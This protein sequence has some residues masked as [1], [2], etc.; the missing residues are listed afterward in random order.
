MYSPLKPEAFGIPTHP[1]HI[2]PSPTNLRDA[3]ERALVE[4]EHNRRRQLRVDSYAQ[5]ARLSFYSAFVRALSNSCSAIVANAHPHGW[6][7]D[8]PPQEIPEVQV[9]AAGPGSGKS[10]AAKAFAVTVARTTEANGFALGCV[11]LVHHVHT[12]NIAH[13]ELEALLPGRVAVF[14]AENDAERGAIRKPAFTAD[15]LDEYPVL[16]TTHEFYKQIR[17]HKA[18]IFTRSGLTLPRVVTFIDEKVEEIQTFDA[19]KKTVEH[20]CEFIQRQE[21]QNEAMLYQLRQFHEFVMQKRYGTHDWETPAHD[22][23]GWSVA[24]RVQWFTTDQAG[25]Y[26]RAQG[27][28]GSDESFKN[29]FGLARSLAERRMFVQRRNGGEQG[30]HY[31]GYERAVPQVIGMVLLDA[32][33][34]IDGTG[35]LCPWRQLAQS[36]LERY[37]R[38]EVVYVHSIAKGTLT[39]WLDDPDHRKRYVQHMLNIV[40]QQVAPEQ[41]ALLVCKRKLVVEAKSIP[42]WS[43]HMPQFIKTTKER[44][45]SASDEGQVTAFPWRYEGRNLAVAWYGGYGIGANDWREADIVLLFDEYY[46]PTRIVI[47]TA[48]GLKGN[49]AGEGI[50]SPGEQ[51]TNH[52]DVEAVKTGHVL[53]WLKQMALRGKGRD[54]DADGVC[55]KQR[56]VVTG[57]VVTLVENFDALFPGAMLRHE[58]TDLDQQAENLSKFAYALMTPGLEDTVA[59]SK[60]AHLM[61]VEWRNVSSDL[62]R[63]RSSQALLHSL[64]WEYVSR[65][66]RVGS[67]FQRTNINANATQENANVQLRSLTECNRPVHG[68]NEPSGT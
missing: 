7:R 38:L 11:L 68:P 24:E 66:G 61:G 22:P 48:Q 23:Q 33:A 6:G 4:I 59:A 29:V 53:R 65:R 3:Y 13:S 36:P 12:A 64:R 16:V 20:V 46:L 9:V 51:A 21:D 60:I 31:V 27:A 52:P 10:T 26:M 49:K 34:D 1:G 50:L 25:R 39:R 43:E 8:H 30:T 58:P 54:F 19:T 17:G 18:R 62:L 57:D 5:K 56:L 32:T 37:D 42:N 28:K 67:V 40:Q 14:T 41:N 45:T 44:M 2:M 35:N 47:A 15:E 55:G 63:H